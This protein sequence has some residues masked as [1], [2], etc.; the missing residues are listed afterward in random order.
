MRNN[1]L[2]DSMNITA[3]SHHNH[4]EALP[5]GIRWDDVRMINKAS[6][7]WLERRFPDEARARGNHDFV[8][9]KKEIN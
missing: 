7:K 6:D 8:Y 3:S 1:D 2:N 9:G 5:F 4:A